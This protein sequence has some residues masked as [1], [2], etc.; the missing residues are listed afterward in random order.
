MQTP[1][2]FIRLGKNLR[3]NKKLVFKVQTIGKKYVQKSLPAKK[4]ANNR[5]SKERDSNQ[6]V[7]SCQFN[8]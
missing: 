4:S 2:F 6:L 5:R 1:S 3:E 8:S 7:I